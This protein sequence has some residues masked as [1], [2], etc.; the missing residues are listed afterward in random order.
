MFHSRRTCL[1][2][3]KP[4]SGRFLIEPKFL[5][6][7]YLFTKSRERHCTA[8]V[9]HKL[10]NNLLGIS[11]IRLRFWVFHVVRVPYFN[12]IIMALNL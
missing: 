11:S 9:D 7:D 1:I 12:S 4:S 2:L 8:D 6:R 3:E 5:N 10:K